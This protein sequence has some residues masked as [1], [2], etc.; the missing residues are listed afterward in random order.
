MRKE[1]RKQ[2][3]HVLAQIVPSV[4]ARDSNHRPPV[5]LAHA[6][7]IELLS[8]VIQNRIFNVIQLDSQTDQQTERPTDGK[9]D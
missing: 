5:W 9:T 3:A 1:G 6:L 7:P 8:K 2:K 4:F